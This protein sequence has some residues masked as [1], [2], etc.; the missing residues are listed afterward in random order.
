MRLII[1]L[2]IF[3]LNT[4]SKDF[5]VCLTGATVKLFKNY[6]EAFE[7]GATLAK[8]NSSLILEKHFYD[9][10]PLAAR[11]AMKKMTKSKCDGIVGFSTGNDLLTIKDLAE[12]FKIPVLS[13]YG[14]PN[15]KLSSEFVKTM[16]PKPEYLLKSLFSKVASKINNLKK[17]LVVTTIDREAMKGYKEAYAKKLKSFNKSVLHVDLIE[18]SGDI[19]KFKEIFLKNRNS[20]DGVVILTRSKMA[21]EI[22]DFINHHKSNKSPL[23]LATKYFGSSALPAYLNYLTNKNVQAYFARHNCLCDKDPAYQ[24]FIE[25]YRASFKKDPMVISAHTFD[26]VNFFKKL[27]IKKEVNAITH[28]G[29]TGIAIKKG[30]QISKS[31]SFV[32][33]VNQRGYQEI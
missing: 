20:I 2:T 6:G 31:K 5:K 1:I 29:I 33:E 19:K 26:A 18:S 23:I 14:D 12:E 24:K 21:A 30:F 22:T 10:T 7:N 8:A 15:S 9:R 13:I 11:D 17:F 27:A 32:I 25:K 4:F 28:T 16:Q 3:S